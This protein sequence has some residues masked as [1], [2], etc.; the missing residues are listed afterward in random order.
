VYSVVIPSTDPDLAHKTAIYTHR[1]GGTTLNHGIFTRKPEDVVTYIDH[2]RQ[3]TPDS[4]VRL[5]HPHAS[6]GEGQAVFALDDKDAILEGCKDLEF[7]GTVIM[8]QLEYIHDRYTIGVINLGRY[9]TYRYI[10]R[11]KTTD[12]NNRE[13]Y[14]GCTIGVVH[15]RIPLDIAARTL[16]I[17]SATIDTGF[18]AIEEYSALVEDAG[19]VSVDIIDGDAGPHLPHRYVAD[20]TPRVGGTTSAE[21]LAIRA[22]QSE[23]TGTCFVES[24]LLYNPQHRPSTGL[25]FID[26][27]DLLGHAHITQLE[28]SRI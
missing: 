17:P 25:V 20:L 1:L 26:A 11:E 22:L 16:D 7:A 27:P 13:V 12:L 24:N 14:G 19:R 4:R 5:K 3:H 28:G 15:S 18:R 23:P 2:L 21:T 8:P 10:G 9:G 6:D